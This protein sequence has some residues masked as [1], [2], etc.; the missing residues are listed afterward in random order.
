[1]KHFEHG[2]FVDPADAP[3][4][5]EISGE[6]THRERIARGAGRVLSILLVLPLFGLRWMF[7]SRRG[8]SILHP[9]EEAP[10]YSEEKSLA[11]AEMVGA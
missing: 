10:V 4:L 5:G 6:P 1:M 9:Q 11:A 7:P 2:E 3:P 8:A